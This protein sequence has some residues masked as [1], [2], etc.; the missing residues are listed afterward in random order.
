[1][2]SGLVEAVGQ[3]TATDSSKD[4]H[5]RTLTINAPFAHQLALGE[6]VSV[7]GVC[8][9]VTATTPDHFQVECTP[10]T[11]AITTL[12]SLSVP[13]LVNLERSVTPTT[14]LGGHWVQGHID[15]QG[16]VVSVVSEGE[17]HHV[18]FA[19]P[20]EFQRLIVP[21][22]S[23]TI[24]GVSLTV[25]HAEPGQFQVTLIPFTQS[26]TTLGSLSVG[27]F[28]NLEFDVLGKYVQQLL[29]PYVDNEKRSSIQ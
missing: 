13:S 3:L 17:A 28:V 4:A 19:Y 15:T 2:F 25:V 14:R 5:A 18:T 11:L 8:L 6:S 22:G 7:N 16:T 12:G 26:H 21:F 27:Q 23:I 9:T 29:T 1:M 10:T 24:D 20:Q